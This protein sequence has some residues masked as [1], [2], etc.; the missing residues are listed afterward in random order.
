MNLQMHSDA[1]KAAGGRGNNLAAMNHYDLG[2]K[3]DPT[4]KLLADPVSHLSR[5]QSE[6]T[7]MKRDAGSEMTEISGL[8][9]FMSSQGLKGFDSPE[10]M[11]R[12]PPTV[13]STVIEKVKA[14]SETDFALLIIPDEDLETLPGGA[15]T[16]I[17]IA[18]TVDLQKFHCGRK[19]K[20]FTQLQE[21][22][23]D[24]LQSRQKNILSTFVLS[25]LEPYVLLPNTPQTYPSS[26][27]R[28]VLF[29]STVD[30]KDPQIRMF[31]S[32]MGCTVVEAASPALLALLDETKEDVKDKSSLL[33]FAFAPHLG[34]CLR[35]IKCGNC[36]TIGSKLKKCPCGKAYYC[37]TEC[38]KAQ[39]RVHK[40]EHKSAPVSKN[41]TAN[42]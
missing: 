6:T 8:N 22:Y 26:R 36:D 29:E 37:S 1:A 38:Q 15:S 18:F 14:L 7:G 42:N 12:K 2:W 41:V 11:L 24:P 31:L 33:A 4:K 16:R 32:M 25:C 21:V 9:K 17:F 20:V 30:S 34:D 40:S 27:P 28:Q 35:G 39:W 3:A 10:E 13:T 23:C 5:R 19:K